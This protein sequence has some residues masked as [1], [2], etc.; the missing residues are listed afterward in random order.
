[1]STSCVT[2]SVVHVSSLL[3]QVSSINLAGVDRVVIA[4]AIDDTK[5]G[6]PGCCVC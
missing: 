1:M 3:V 5:V 2:S 6:G 4:Y